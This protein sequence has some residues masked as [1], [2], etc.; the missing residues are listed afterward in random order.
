MYTHISWALA[1]INNN[2]RSISPWILDNQ[3]GPGSRRQRP[4][5]D[6]AP[7]SPGGGMDGRPTT[8]RSPLFAAF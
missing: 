7:F 8:C 5:L 4:F 2:I 3:Y 1:N 6:Q